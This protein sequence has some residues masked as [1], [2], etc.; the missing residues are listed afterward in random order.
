MDICN[1]LWKC[2][3]VFWSF[4]STSLQ[5]I[6]M[7]VKGGDSCTKTV[8][9]QEHNA[10]MSDSQRVQELEKA[11]KTFDT[12]TQNRLFFFLF[13]IWS[14]KWESHFH[15]PLLTRY[16]WIAQP[17]APPPFIT[18][19]HN[20]CSLSWRQEESWVTLIGATQHERK[21]FTRACQVSNRLV[22]VC[23]AENILSMDASNRT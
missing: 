5:N 9:G 17:Q 3:Y 14:Y 12:D 10:E 15:L 13:S 23:M 11:G 21:G 18:P 22:F 6:W 7:S 20:I 16:N 8:R 4:I 19:P 1:N 2:I